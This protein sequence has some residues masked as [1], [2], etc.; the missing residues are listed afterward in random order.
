MS[1]VAGARRKFDKDFREGA[2][3]LVRETGKPIAQVARELGVNE[4]TLGSWIARDRR[5]REGEDGRVCEGEQA[6]LVR[7]SDRSAQRRVSAL[8][9]SDAER[10]A[11]AGELGDHFAAG[12][13]ALDELQRR[14]GSVFSA[15]TQ[16]Q[17]TRAMRDLPRPQVRPLQPPAPAPSGR[18]SDQD[19][20][21]AGRDGRLAAAAQ[22]RGTVPQ[23]RSM[24]EAAQDPAKPT[25][26][27]GTRSRD[28]ADWAWVKKV[29]YV[30]DHRPWVYP[31]FLIALISVILLAAWLLVPPR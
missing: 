13:L 22:D 10:D 12:R 3:R 1:P 26:D 16:G 27:Q 29:Q 30:I 5:R 20:T 9:V 25:P 19:E 6:E 7:G 11:A 15:R 23:D 28:P 18:G 21:S 17:L 4:R 8:R 31:L 14:L 24:L 2:V